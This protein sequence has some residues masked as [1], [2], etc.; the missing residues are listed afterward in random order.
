MEGIRFWVQRV[1]IQLGSQ[2]E[3]AV[4][5]C[6]NEEAYYIVVDVAGVDKDDLEVEY[7][8]NGSLVVRGVRRPPNI[9]AVQCLILEI[10]YGP[11]E[12]R[13]PLPSS[14]DPEGITAEYQSGLLLVRVP[15]KSATERVRLVQI[16]P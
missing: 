13:I 11:F 3:P 10:P 8:P 4:D 5:V 12:R 1:Q 9:G 7:H 16:K 6:E 2:W 14:I 15:K